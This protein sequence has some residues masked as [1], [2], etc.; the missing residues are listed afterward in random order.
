[1]D[2]EPVVVAEVALKESEK[3]LAAERAPELVDAV[4]AKP[5][6]PNAAARREKRKQRRR[7]RPHGRAR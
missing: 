6:G 5:S 4:T 2:E 1:V 3:A 7:S